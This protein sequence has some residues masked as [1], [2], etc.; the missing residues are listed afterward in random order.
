MIEGLYHFKGMGL[1]WL[2]AWLVVCFLFYKTNKK[3]M[4]LFHEISTFYCFP[5]SQIGYF[6]RNKIVFFMCW[7]FRKQKKSIRE[8]LILV[9]FYSSGTVKACP[10]A[11]NEGNSTNAYFPFIFAHIEVIFDSYDK[12]GLFRNICLEK[13]LIYAK[14][15][16]FLLFLFFIF[17]Y[18]CSS[19]VFKKY[20]KWIVRNPF[21]FVT[22][23]I[24][25][26][27]F[28]FFVW[29]SDFCLEWDCGNRFSVMLFEWDPKFFYLFLRRFLFSDFFPF[30]AEK[31]GEREEKEFDESRFFLELFYSRER[32]RIFF[33]ALGLKNWK[34]LF[35]YRLR[36]R[37]LLD[38]CFR[39]KKR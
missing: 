11:R 37:R 39:W 18:I 19:F 3:T 26:L 4:N 27:Y 38:L 12:I 23:A 34:F 16:L 1:W 17:F 10:T 30:N 22:F 14:R 2:G 15:N 5:G 33:H 21:S 29:K 6:K 31:T 25:K 20:R 13:Y 36:V 32:N 7:M 8:Q 35:H 24:S 9:F 28:L